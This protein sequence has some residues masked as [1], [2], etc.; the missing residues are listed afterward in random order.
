MMLLNRIAKEAIKQ[1]QNQRK[2]LADLIISSLD[3][4]MKRGKQN[5]KG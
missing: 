5:K 3:K 2:E 4:A 1:H